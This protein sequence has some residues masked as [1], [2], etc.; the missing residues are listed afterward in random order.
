MP[1]LPSPLCGCVM[2][3]D[4][5]GRQWIIGLGGA[6]V[7]C[8]ISLKHFIHM[9]LYYERTALFPSE[10]APTNHNIIE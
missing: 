2:S 4:E 9:Q 6:V 10:I 3:L 5:I 8:I 1:S 7:E